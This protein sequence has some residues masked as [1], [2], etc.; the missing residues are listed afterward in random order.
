MW[1]VVHNMI[2]N[3]TD[4]T[5]IQLRFGPMVHC[6]KWYEDKVLLLCVIIMIHLNAMQF[7]LCC[8]G[9]QSAWSETSNRLWLVLLMR[10][11]IVVFS[12]HRFPRGNLVAANNKMV[13]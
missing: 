11:V 10:I 6:S 12:N 4:R 3:F 5:I 9:L 2:V 1:H 8:S 13:M 7:P